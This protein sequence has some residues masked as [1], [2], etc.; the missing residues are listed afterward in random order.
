MVKCDPV[1][2]LEYRDIR[3]TRKEKRR[4]FGG[5]KKIS[6]SHFGSEPTGKTLYKRKKHDKKETLPVTLMPSQNRKASCTWVKLRGGSRGGTK[7]NLKGKL[8]STK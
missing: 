6:G 3:T 8:Q 1:E 2:S 7:G 5:G 4:P